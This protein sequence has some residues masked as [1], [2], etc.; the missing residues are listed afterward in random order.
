MD[1]TYQI[2]VKILCLDRCISSAYIKNL[3]EDNEFLQFAKYD[4]FLDCDQV[5]IYLN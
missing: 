5:G 3:T 1:E 4:I 2:W